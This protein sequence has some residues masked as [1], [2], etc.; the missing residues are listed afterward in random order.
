MA[1]K[2]EKIKRQG[3]ASERI[4]I[5]FELADDAASENISRADRYV[6]LARA[7]GMRYNVGIPGEHKRKFCK[8][9][10]K[11]LLPSVTSRTRINSP[12]HRVEIT[13][14]NCKKKMFFPYVKEKKIKRS[15]HGLAAH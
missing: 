15:Q 4:K 9:C 5:L 11:Y 14:L 7:V 3:I 10:N 12:G 2:R 13:C 1:H 8:Y 6:E